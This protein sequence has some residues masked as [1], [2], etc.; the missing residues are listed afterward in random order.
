MASSLYGDIK[1]QNAHSLFIR[2]QEGL[3]GLREWVEQ[4]YLPP[5]PD[6]AVLMALTKRGGRP[7]QVRGPCT[8]GGAA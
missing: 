3:F 6:N 8:F 4:G 7:P 2:P 5:L 1:R